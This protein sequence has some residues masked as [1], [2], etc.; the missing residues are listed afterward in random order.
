[1]AGNVTIR[2]KDCPAPLQAS[3]PS[4]RPHAQEYISGDGSYL[5]QLQKDSEV[6]FGPAFFRA[7]I[8]GGDGKLKLDFG[9]RRFFSYDV[10]AHDFATPPSPWNPSSPCVVLLE[11]LNTRAAP[12]TKIARIVFLDV[13]RK[14]PLDSWDFESLISHRT[15]SLDGKF[16]LFRDVHEI[17]VFSSQEHKL[18]P[19]ANSE[20]AHCFLLE[21][22]LVCVVEKSGQLQIYDAYSAKRLASDSIA[23]PGYTLKRAIVN[24]ERSAVYLTLGTAAGRD[25][26]ELS[27]VAAVEEVR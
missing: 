17:Y 3:P 13:L 12:G 25:T 26:P 20:S 9:G 6:R 1:M 4:A 7:A 23:E 24:D 15:W 10:Q 5:L 14:Q 18:I 2:I 22:N 11:M 19:I 8:F 16:Y 21:G 27:Y